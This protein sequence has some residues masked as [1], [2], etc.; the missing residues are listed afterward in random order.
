M[1]TETKPA[2]AAAKPSD[3]ADLAERVTA[4]EKIVPK[5]TKSAEPVEEA[6]LFACNQRHREVMADVRSGQKTAIET[7]KR[8]FADT[9]KIPG[10][11]MQKPLAPH[12]L[13]NV[14]KSN[15]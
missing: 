6:P 8:A 3:N 15:K 7:I 10:K 2:P 14:A 11:R 1:M 5:R 9:F 12:A 13:P 4:L